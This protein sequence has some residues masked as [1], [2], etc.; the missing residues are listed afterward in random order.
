MSEWEVKELGNL[1]SEKGYIRGPFGSSLKRGEMVDE[2]ISVYEQKNAIYNSRDFRFFITPEKFKV[3]KRFQVRTNDLIIS[4]SGTVGKI[5]IIAEN[6]PKGIISQALLILRPDVKKITLRFLYYFL[7]SRQ[8]FNLITQASHGSVQVNIAARKVVETIPVP[9]PPLLEQ[10]AIASILSSLDDKIDLL[11]RQNKTLEAMAETLFR[12]W[13]VEEADEGWERVKL[14]Q[15]IEVMRG[16]SY[17]G[18][19]LAEKGNGVPMH[20]LNSVYEGGGYKY[21]GI[22]YY[23]GDY[24]ERH[25]VKPGDVIITNTEQGHDL[26]LIGYPA[27]VPK[28]FG[29]FGIFSQHIYRL[30]LK[31]KRIT[32]LFL[33]YLLMSYGV[34]EQLAGATNGSTVNM[35]PKDGIEWAKFKIPP[36]G[37]IKEFTSVVKPLLGKKESNYSQIRTLEKL[38]DTMLS[39]LMSGEVRVSY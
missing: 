37:K 27:I 29:D 15:F 26:L 17:K 8:G 32:E 38:R 1:L 19:G 10:R 21:E 4:C 3:L 22:K 33:Y 12:Q 23:S 9:V 2:G 39:K 13:F 5:S 24:R 7:S 31:D 20:N 36:D 14:G 6:D 35:L 11:H 16:L 30:R 28:Y 18:A 34:R 25:L